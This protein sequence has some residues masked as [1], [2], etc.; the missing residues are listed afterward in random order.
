MDEKTPESYKIEDTVA[1]PTMMKDL[2]GDNSV[3]EEE[4]KKLAESSSVKHI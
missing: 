3:E 4:P 2:V 1:T